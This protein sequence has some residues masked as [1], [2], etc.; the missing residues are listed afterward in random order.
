LKRQQ[1]LEFY[2]K[3]ELRFAVAFFLGGFLFDVFTLGDID[4]PLA[5]AQQLLYFTIIGAFLYF[6]FLAD[7]HA[8]YPPTEGWKNRV[9]Q[10]RSLILHFFLGSLLSV[11][12]LFFLKSA[13]VFSSILFAG[14]LLLLLVLNELK[15]VQ[16][17]AVDIKIVIFIVCVFCFFSLMVPVALGFVGRIPFLLSLLLT[18]SAIFAGYKLLFQRTGDRHLVLHRFVLPSG[19]AVAGFVLFYLMGWIPP[20][21]LSA[22]KLGIYHKAERVGDQYQLYHENPWWKFWLSGD[23]HFRAAPGDK[24]YVFVSVFS[25]ARFED[26]VLL[27]WS[28]KDPRQGWI[29]SD[30][31]SMR[32]TGGRKGGYRGVTTKQNFTEGDWRVSVQTTDGAEL[33]RLHFTVESLSEAPTERVWFVDSY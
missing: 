14:A 10:Y 18:L 4:D 31:I 9:W 2:E 28:Y 22:A 21:P 26:S 7:I 24:L 30:K 20:V 23:Q 13:S 8:W 6:D 32:V 15:S 27:E 17:S 1:L 5:I 19:L 16:Q 33:S 11:Y 25:P 29:V 12:S 3:H